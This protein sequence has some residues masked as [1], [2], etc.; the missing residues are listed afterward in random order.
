MGGQGFGKRRGVK[1]DSSWR[2]VTPENAVVAKAVPMLLERGTPSLTLDIEGVR[3]RLIIY[4]GS[5]VSIMK[6]GVVSR[7][8]S[9]TPLKPFGV[10]GKTLEPD[11]R[12]LPMKSNL[13]VT[14]ENQGRRVPAIPDKENHATLVAVCKFVLEQIRSANLWRNTLVHNSKA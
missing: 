10:T 1:E 12:L 4:T 13:S 7:D 6:P 5:N 2:L 9:A 8:I 11:K 3:R 14:P